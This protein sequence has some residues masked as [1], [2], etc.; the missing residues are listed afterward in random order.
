MAGVHKNLPL[1]NMR[2]G[3]GNLLFD[4]QVRMTRNTIDTNLAA[5]VI[6]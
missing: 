2:V 6:L 1:G 4:G 3:H 5:L